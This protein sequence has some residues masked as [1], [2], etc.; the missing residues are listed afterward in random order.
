MKINNTYNPTNHLII[1]DFLN[2]TVL[3]KVLDKPVNTEE[4][5]ILLTHFLQYASIQGYY[6]HKNKTQPKVRANEKNR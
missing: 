4:S 1:Q 6:L 3:N 2:K 5:N